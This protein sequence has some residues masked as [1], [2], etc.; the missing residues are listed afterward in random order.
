MRPGTAQQAERCRRGKLAVRRWMGVGACVCQLVSFPPR[1][2]GGGG[3]FV[4]RAGGDDT[5]LG[6]D[7]R[8]VLPASQPP[9]G[10]CLLS[11]GGEEAAMCEHVALC[12]LLS[13]GVS[14]VSPRPMRQPWKNSTSAYVLPSRRV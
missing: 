14:L 7:S 10:V 8:A 5:C 11:E 6:V 3:V 1:V 12:L 13:W 4:G 2:G 9:V